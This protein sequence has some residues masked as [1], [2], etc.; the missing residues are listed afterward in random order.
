MNTIRHA[1]HFDS[2]MSATGFW[3]GLTMGRV[4]LGFVTPRVG[5]RLAVS[6]YLTLAIALEL[7][8]WLVPVYLVSTVMIALLGFFMGPLFPAA[9]VAATRLLPR[10]LHVSGVGLA[11][12]VGGAGAAIVPFV[13]GAIVTARGVDKLQPVALALVAVMLAVWLT[14]PRLPRPG[15]RPGSETGLR[16]LMRRLRR[17]KGAE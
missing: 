16:V 7:L 8:F 2:G 11:A 5:E 13:T 14:L 3:L 17:K 6:I 4:T 10:H 1:S 12:S 15:E 9:I